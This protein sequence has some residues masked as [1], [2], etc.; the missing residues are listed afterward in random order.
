MLKS[1]LQRYLLAVVCLALVP[2]AA[3]AH[4]TWVEA[5]TSLIRTGDAVYLDL[6]LGNHGNHHRD[7][8]LASKLTLDGCT[9]RVIAPEGQRYDLLPDVVDTGYAP[10][11]GF[12]SAKFVPAKPGLYCVAHRL[13]RVVNH[14]RPVRAVKSGKTYFTVSPTLDRVKPATSGFEKPLGHEF[15][16]VPQVNPVVPMG[17]GQPITVLLLFRG[18]P[19]ADAVVSFVPSRETLKEG[20]DETYERKTGVDGMASFTP[21]TGDRFLVVA[22][23]HAD[24]AGEQY[25]A[26]AWSA[27]LTVLVPE[28]CPCCGEQ[29]ETSP[30]N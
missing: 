23:H 29:G 7:F 6:K 25:E 17:P 14:G 24:E 21:K 9:F 19:L 27:T 15:E 16:L 10:K 13:D 26:T 2:A 28:V 1:R 30:G 3:T 11:E 22:H 18:K 5:N 4:D 8:K 12:W 20:F